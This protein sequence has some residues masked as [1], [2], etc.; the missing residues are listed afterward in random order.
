MLADAGPRG[1]L[2]L[3]G[4]ISGVYLGNAATGGVATAGHNVVDGLAGLTLAAGEGAAGQ[5]LA[6]GRRS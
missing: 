4:D 2:A 6:T 1:G 3:D 5:A